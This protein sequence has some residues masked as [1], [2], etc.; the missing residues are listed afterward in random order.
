M[1]LNAVANDLAWRRPPPQTAHF[2]WMTSH[3]LL[4]SN[5]TAVFCQTLYDIGVLNHC[6]PR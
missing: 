1:S 6:C 5:S 2:L 4:V 3:R